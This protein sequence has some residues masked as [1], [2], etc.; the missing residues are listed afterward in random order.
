MTASRLS[1]RVAVLIMLAGMAWGIVMAVSHDHSAMPAHAHLNLL[2]F[3]SL[4]L[5][6]VFYHLHPAIDRSRVAL[7]QVGVWIAATVVMA[8]G[9]GLVHTGRPAGAPLAAASSIVA[10]ADMLLFTWLVFRS[11]GAAARVTAAAE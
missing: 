11:D 5:F 3:V 6:G 9:V 10:I 4:F 8:I 2:G 1:F 7:V